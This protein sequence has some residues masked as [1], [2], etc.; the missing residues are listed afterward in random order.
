MGEFWRLSLTFPCLPFFQP[1]LIAVWRFSSWLRSLH[2][3]L[4]QLSDGDVCESK[5]DDWQ[6]GDQNHLCRRPLAE[7]QEP[8]NRCPAKGCSVN[9]MSNDH[10]TQQ[11]KQ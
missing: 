5:L 8:W 11:T 6:L 2:M 4:Y 9:C 3:I 7:R 10:K 1:K